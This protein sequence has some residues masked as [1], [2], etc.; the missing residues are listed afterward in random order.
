MK[1][2]DELRYYRQRETRSQT[3]AQSSTNEL[4][5][6]WST[7]G[8][9]TATNSVLD[10]EWL[11][12]DTKR[13]IIRNRSNWKPML[14]KNEVAAVE[15]PH[16]GLS[17]NP[18]FSH[19]QQLLVTAVANVKAKLKQEQ[20]IARATST[21]KFEGDG[22]IPEVKD[23]EEDSEEDDDKSRFR[24]LPKPK[25]K[26]QKRKEKEQREREVKLKEQKDKVG[27]K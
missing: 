13:N 23:E 19:H 5:D 10:N 25:T 17:Y 27:N 16:P 9:S 22:T 12:P 2:K 24:K 21:P 18:S 20:K 26:Q 15:V 6:L 14:Q 8:T 3:K 7:T 1:F 11:T 4:T